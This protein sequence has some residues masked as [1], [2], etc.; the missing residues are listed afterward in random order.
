[1]SPL[2]FKDDVARDDV[3]WPV[4]KDDV[5]WPVQAPAPTPTPAAAKAP[6]AS[7]RVQRAKANLQKVGWSLWLVF[8]GGGLAVCV[9]T[10]G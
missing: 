4:C 1:M 2:V 10:W 9:Y 6:P 7:D 3:V 8:G 5:V